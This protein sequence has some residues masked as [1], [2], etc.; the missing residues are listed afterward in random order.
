MT[1]AATKDYF[2][3]VFPLIFDNMRMQIIL[4]QMFFDNS[5]NNVQFYYLHTQFFV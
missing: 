2:H 1:P 4:Q 5:R 3:Q